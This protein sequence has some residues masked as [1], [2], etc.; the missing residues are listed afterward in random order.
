VLVILA[1]YYGPVSLISPVSS[2]YPALLA[3]VAVK[4]SKDSVGVIQG[5]G[6]GI[7]AGGLI[8]IGF[9]GI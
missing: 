3:L 9:S 2:V 6:I 4:F 8:V 5:I 7:I 1:F